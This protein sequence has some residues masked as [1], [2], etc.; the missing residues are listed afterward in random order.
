VLPAV[1]EWAAKWAALDGCRPSPRRDLSE[2]GVDRETWEG[3]RAGAVVDLY[4]LE[5]GGHTWPGA[6]LELG[7][8][9]TA[10]HV[11]ATEVIWRFFA[12]HS[13]DVSG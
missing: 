7:R 4:T 1:R 3:S 2:P 10:E 11:R 9:A 6:R 13:L 12:E 8:T 5:G